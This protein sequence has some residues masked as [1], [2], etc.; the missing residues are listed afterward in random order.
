M[1]KNQKRISTGLFQI[2]LPFSYDR[3]DLQSLCLVFQNQQFQLFSLN[4]HEMETSYYGH[5]SVNHSRLETDF[6]PYANKILFPQHVDKGFVRYSKKLNRYSP[7]NSPFPYQILSA[8]LIFC[9]YHIGFL[10]VRLEI[11]NPILT[12]TKELNDSV[13]S[14]APQLIRENLLNTGELSLLQFKNI[15]LASLISFSE[16]ESIESP[17]QCRPFTYMTHENQCIFCFSCKEGNLFNR[18]AEQFFGSVYYS[19]LIHLFFNQIFIDIVGQYSIIHTERNKKEVKQILFLINAFMS[20]Y[21][22]VLSPATF[23]TKE[24]FELLRKS[25]CIDHLYANIKD[26]QFTLFKYQEEAGK[27]RDSLLLLILTLYTVICG[28]FSMNLFT[29]DLVGNIKWSHFKSYNP[30]EYFAVFIVFSGMMVVGFLGLQ[31]L[32]VT[33][34]DKKSQNKWIVKSIY[35]ATSKRFKK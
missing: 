2:I 25:F 14:M 32:Y 13:F 4:D 3:A 26:I 12:Q 22:Y 18:S 8:D 17:E 6:L 10:T 24:V 7:A 19:L 1:K 15:F 5:F 21:Y 16:S 28:I 20:N 11:N 29:H 23:A 33:Y 30:F 9:P 27:K 31:S 35:S 34:Q